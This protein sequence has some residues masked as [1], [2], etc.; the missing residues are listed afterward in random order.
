MAKVSVI[1]G[2]YNCNDTDG[3][4]KSVDSII[5][6]TYTDWEF[7]ICNDGSTDNTLVT[8]REI[9]KLDKRI[10]VLTYENNRGLAY[11]LNTC[12]KEA[13]GIY[14]ARMDDDDISRP[15]RLEKQIEFLDK[16]GNIAFTG[17]IANVFN[18]DGIWG[19]LKMPEYPA[20][21][22]FLWNIPFIHPSMVFRK[23]ALEG[24]GGYNIEP[25]NRRCEDYT[26]VMEMYSKGYRGYNF[27]EPLIDY[28]IDNGDKKYRLMKDRVHEAI[29]RYRGY[30]INGMLLKGIPYIIK[31]LIVGM[32]PQTVFREI[33]KVQYKN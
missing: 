8:L 17:S 10:K 24:V 6:Q 19:M 21:E 4:Y 15:D 32:I 26:L 18:K 28:R 2:V 14:I 30:K 27:Q 12:L 13:K 23:E 31:P 11:A 16:N 9:E 22:D 33:K 25:V 29:V 5:K 20:K 3:L 7:I 1:M